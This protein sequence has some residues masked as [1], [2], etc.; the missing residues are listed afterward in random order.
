ML[1]TPLY[2]Y[3]RPLVDKFVGRGNLLLAADMGTGKTICSIAAAEILLGEDL[4]DQVLI[5]CP[6]GL[7]IQWAKEIARHTDVA[8]YTR[9]SRALKSIVPTPQHCLIIDGAG[10]TRE[11]MLTQALRTRP[12]YVIIG[13]DTVISDYVDVCEIARDFVILDEAA[14]IK[15]PAAERSQAIKSLRARYR[16]AMTGTPVENKAEELFSLMEW[17]DET[18]L[19]RPDMFDKTFIVRNKWGAIVRYKHLDVLHKKVSAAMARITIDHPDVAIHMPKRERELWC[20][21]MTDRAMETYRAIAEHLLEEM[22]ENPPTYGDWDV[23]AHYAGRPNESTPD[24]RMMAMHQAMLMFL[25]HPS[26]VLA[27]AQAYS[28]GLLTE[29]VPAHGSR[30]AHEL[31]LAGWLDDMDESEKLAEVAHRVNRHFRDDPASKVIIFSGYRGMLPLLA[32]ALPGIGHVR[33]HGEMSTTQKTAS[34]TRFQEDPSVRLLLS[35][36]AGAYGLDLPAA[37]LLVNY[38]S[39]WSHGRQS[40]IDRRHVRASSRHAVVAVADVVTQGTVE[41]RKLAVSQRKGRAAAAMLDGLGHE[42]LDRGVSA[43]GQGLQEHLRLFL[44]GSGKRHGVPM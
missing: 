2:P 38:D 3:Q 22:E 30:F 21:G 12:E 32:D 4:I 7:K 25:D 40:Q 9:R 5:I 33:Y 37:N 42:G 16:L 17:V 28:V 13:Y 36:H 35:T 44:K 34:Q 15:N 43:S 39:A 19:G 27:S 41:E 11:M 10:P 31:W 20:V 23:G 8:T 26:L 6:P 24:G 18:V 29:E 14:V 1:T